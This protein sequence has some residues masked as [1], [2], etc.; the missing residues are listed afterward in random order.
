MQTSAMFDKYSYF[1]KGKGNNS[2]VTARTVYYHGYSQ[3]CNPDELLFHIFK[4]M[5]VGGFLVKEQWNC[6]RSR[7]TIV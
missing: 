7:I 3:L 1:P 6:W 4:Q 5:L 2:P